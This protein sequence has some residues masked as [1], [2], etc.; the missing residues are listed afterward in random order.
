MQHFAG[1]K[2]KI[3]SFYCDN[4]PELIAAA[5]ALTWRLSTATTGMPQTNGVAE[6]S[7]RRTK[8]E[9][10][11][12]GVVQ[13]GFNPP[14]F[15]PLAGEHYCISANIAIADGDSAYN[16]RRKLGHFKGNVSLVVPSL[17][18]CPNPILRLRP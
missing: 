7:V 6:N 3:L 8:E 11:G 9:G 12:C 16:R 13:S 4:A 18:S 17:T 15:W 10:G 14:T 1:D 2:D 5:T